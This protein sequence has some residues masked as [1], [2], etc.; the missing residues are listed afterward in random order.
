[1]AQ[2]LQASEQSAVDLVLTDLGMPNPHGDDLVARLLGV[3]RPPVVVM[4]TAFPSE[5][6]LRRAGELGVLLLEK[7]F[8]MERL[9]QAVRQAVSL[10]G[11]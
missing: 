8:S 1:V 4:M 5:E 9:A 6:T 7:P 10:R 2:A 11:G 3:A